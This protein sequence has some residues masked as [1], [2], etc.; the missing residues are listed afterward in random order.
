MRLHHF[1]LLLGL[2]TLPAQAPSRP[3]DFAVLFNGTDL[4]GWDG[5]QAFWSVQEGAITGRTTAAHPASANTFL[6][7]KG[8]VLENFELRLKFRI[9]ADNA[10]G[11]ANSGVQYRSRLLDSATWAVAGYQADLD[12]PG[13][14]VGTFYEERGRGILAQP[15]AGSRA[16]ITP[17]QWNE[18]VI[19]VEGN[20]HRYYVNG[21]L[22]TDAVDRD[23][24]RAARAGIL[25]LQLHAGPPMTVQFKDIRLTRLP[26]RGPVEWPVYGGGP[27]SIRYSSLTQINRS[28]V[29][30]LKV[31]WTFDASDGVPSSELEVNPIVVNGVLYATTVSLNVI[32]L[33]AATGALRWRFDPYRGR[34]V[35]G[36]GGRT[37][38][39]T[40]WSDSAGRD[41]R[42][43]VGV[44]QFLYALDAKTGRPIPTFGAGGRIDMREGLRPGEKLMISLGTPGIVYKDLLIVGSRTAE[45]L[46]TP[47]GDVRAYD[48]RTGA[49]RWTFHTIP[50]PGEFGYDTWPKDAWTYTGAANN[51]TGMSLDARRGLVFVPTGSA[52]DDYYGANRAGDNLFAN[53][54]I[55]L[56]AQTG[57]RVWHFQFV[58]HDIWDRDLPAPPNLVTVRRDGRPIDA[59]AQV[60]KSGHVFVFER[61]TGRPLFPI[62]YRG[63]P[64]SDVEGEVAADSQPLPLVPEPFTRQALTEDML[65]DRTPDA[66]RAMLERFRTL[67]SGG[68][69]VPAS[70]QGTIVFPGLDGGAEWGGAAVDPQTSV[71][72]VN[73]NEMPWTVALVERP[74]ATGPVRGQELY[75]AQCAGCHGADR[76]GSPPTFPSLVDLSDRLTTPEIRAV[77]ADGTGRMPGFAHLGSDALSAIQNYILSSPSGPPPPE[78]RGGQG[79]R[80]EGSGGTGA[81]IDQK[82]RVQYG[83]FVDPDGYP[84]V[85]PPWGTLSAIDLNTGRYLWK[86]PLGE[87]RQLAE[88]GMGGTGCENYGGPVVTAGGLVFIGAT[89]YDNKFRAFDKTTGELLWET[90][91]PAAGNATPATYEVN[92]RQFVVIA[93]SSG[94]SRTQAPASYVAFA[95]DVNP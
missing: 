5:D 18:Y 8:G 15:A 24:T 87:Y 38:G 92:G 90:T 57:K 2:T 39:V 30:R 86:I 65:T 53:S 83:R 93:T 71:L 88:Q 60:T 63:Y 80:P 72:Y 11:W 25:A 51:W 43:F 20:R 22:T 66:H 1:I 12:L 54:L 36:G 91:L 75:L 85:K 4:S 34:N 46:P 48:A 16:A 28:N 74:P 52:A 14:Y 81:R 26:P 7:W 31:A 50:R 27:E 94:K 77:M 69:F 33:D 49:V 9:V 19:H 76:K 6:I 68:Q 44:Q 73:A 95:L 61:A 35:R 89:N 37:R 32:A 42:I 62:Q 84:G 17:G 45:A 82:Y 70:L 58:R 41:Q 23:E 78:R 47:P 29:Q 56:N 59:V 55:A 21:R 79:V 3:P 13:T 10:R 64:K 40:Y 67:R